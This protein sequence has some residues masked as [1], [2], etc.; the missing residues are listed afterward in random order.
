MAIENITEFNEDVI[1]IEPLGDTPKISGLELRKTFDKAGA[2]IKEYI[3]NSLVSKVNDEIIKDVNSN[4][5]SISSIN[6][7]ITNMN[8]TLNTVNTSV[9]KVFTSESGSSVNTTPKI[10]FSK[11][12]PTTASTNY[13]S[14]LPVG[15]VVFVY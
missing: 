6:T 9:P 10:V 3:N 5:S 2:D 13:G 1:N 8:N 12:I 14:K 4:T 11:T 7:N 15:S